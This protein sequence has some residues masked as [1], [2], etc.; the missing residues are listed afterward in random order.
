MAQLV[1]TPTGPLPVS[2]YGQLA[3]TNTSALLSTVTKGTKSTDL[4]ST[5]GLV[6]VANLGTSASVVYVNPL[7]TPAL[8]T[9]GVPIAPGSAYGFNLQNPSLASIIAD[10]TATV[11]LQW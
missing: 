8:T 4:P 10:S 5:P 9:T 6:F 7:G 3:V 1:I 11:S 2:G